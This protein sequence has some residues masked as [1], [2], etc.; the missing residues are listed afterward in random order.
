[1]LIPPAG[2]RPRWCTRS[3]PSCGAGGPRSGPSASG[4]RATSSRPELGALVRGK[5]LAVDYSPNGAIPYLDG[6]PA[7]VAE[8]L[9]EPGRHA[10]VVGR[11]GDALLL[12]VDA[13]GRRLAPARR[14]G[15]RGHR[16]RG[17]GARG[18][19]GIALRTPI[20][21]HALAM[22]VRE[23]FDRAGLVTESGPSVSW[24]PNAARA[25]YDPTAEESAPIV[26]GACC[27]STCGPPSRAGSTPTRP[28]W[29]RSA[30]RPSATRGCGAWCARRGT[31]R[32]S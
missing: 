18:Q 1:M 19:P 30:P 29:P 16:P 3:T 31:P 12:G 5:R 15:D 6:V 21:E 8:L 28:G 26:P 13:G 14:G 10:G 20:T 24:G 4:S 7:G 17:A 11:S 2:R 22:W 32:S 25:H 23:R 9:R 27:C